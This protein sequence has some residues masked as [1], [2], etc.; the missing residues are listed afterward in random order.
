MDNLK[1]E[2][3]QDI[4]GLFKTIILLYLHVDAGFN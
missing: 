2:E 3:N 4:L 1:D